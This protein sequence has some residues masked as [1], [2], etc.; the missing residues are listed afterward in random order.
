MLCLGCKVSIGCDPLWV[1]LAGGW[2]LSV[3]TGAV[4]LQARE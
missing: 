1:D 2:G 3:R 4:S